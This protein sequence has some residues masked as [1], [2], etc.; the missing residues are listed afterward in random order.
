MK[1]LVNMPRLSSRLALLLPLLACLEQPAGA[2][3]P[4]AG[5]TAGVAAAPQGARLDHIVADIYGKPVDLKS[6]RGKALLIVNTASECGFTPQYA[7]LEALYR[8]YKERGLVVLAFPSNDFG[9]QEP[10]SN[11]T[12]ESFTKENFDITFPLFDKI[13]ARGPEKAPLFRTLTEESAPRLRGEVRWNFTKFLVNPEGYVVE[14]FESMESPTST[15]VK[16]AIEQVL[17]KGTGKGSLPAPSPT[18]T[19]TREG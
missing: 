6:L 10:G 8:Q 12:I 19:T 1:G 4:S 5:D 13:H 3:P 9:G 7:G 17:P 18:T 15:R 2:A 11:E 16:A 14:R